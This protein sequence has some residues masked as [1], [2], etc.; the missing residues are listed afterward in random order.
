MR[1]CIIAAKNIKH[2]T[3]ISLYTNLF[4]KYSISYDIV[5]PD[6][7]GVSESW[8]GANKIYKY[9]YVLN[10]KN[11]LNWFF[12]KILKLG[13]I[14][15]M[16]KT[17]KKNNY[18]FIVIWG[19]ETAAIMP[20]T[21]KKY[22]YTV[23]IRDLWEDKRKFYNNNINMAIQNATFNTVSSDKF[24]PYLPKADYL[25]IHSAN[26]N[27]LKSLKFSPK[28]IKFPIVITNIGTFRNRE[29]SFKFLDAFAND[30]RFEIRFIGHGSEEIQSYAEKNKIKNVITIGSFPIE[31]TTKYLEG[32]DIMNCAYGDESFV[33]TTKMP[34]RFYYAIYMGIP[35]IVSKGTYIESM[36][37][38]VNGGFS[39]PKNF[40]IKN[41]IGDFIYNKY[42]NLDIEQLRYSYKN[43]QREIEISHF[44]FEKKLC[45]T[46]NIKYIKN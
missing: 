5:Y 28:K 2:L 21:L 17:L 23:N 35:M 3:L 10:K 6:Y 12:S 29:Y 22:K 8:N 32:T 26:M 36:S 34:I 27:I 33:E 38:K 44:N 31:Q 45:S 42:N 11:K 18:D 46:L 39:L 7:Y 20:N 9:S 43:F 15:F 41:D 14:R 30:K 25:Y 24:I 1:A 40:Y 16:K 4:D 13:F 19:N 37:L